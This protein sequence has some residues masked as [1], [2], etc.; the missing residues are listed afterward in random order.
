MARGFRKS[1]DFNNFDGCGF[2]WKWFYRRLERDLTEADVELIA[3]GDINGDGQTDYSLSLSKNIEYTFKGFF[4]HSFSWSREIEK[5]LVV[6]SGDDGPKVRDLERT[7]GVKGPVI[8]TRALGD[9]NGDGF[10]DFATFVGGGAYYGIGGPD[11]GPVGYY[12]KLVDDVYI[13]FGGSRQPATSVGNL[14][15]IDGKVLN[16]KSLGDIN[17]DGID[18]MAA[19]VGSYYGRGAEAGYYGKAIDD[20]YV[21]LGGKSGLAPISLGA[22]GFT[23]S[24][25]D[26]NALG[27]INGDGFVDLAA[28]VG[29]YYGYY[30]RDPDE[31]SY[32]GQVTED[33]FVLFGSEDGYQEKQSLTGLVDIKAKVVGVDAIG[34]IN[35][36]GLSDFA[37]ELGGYY[38]YY[39][40]GIRDVF[41]FLGGDET[42]VSLGSLAGREKTAI[43]VFDLGDINGDGL[44][45]IGIGTA[46]YYG[47][48]YGQEVEDVLV[49]FGNPDGT[50]EVANLNDFVGSKEPLH[51][52]TALGDI[53]G[54]GFEDFTVACGGYYGPGMPGEAILVFGGPDVALQS[55]NLKDFG[56]TDDAFGDIKALGDTNGDGFADFSIAGYYGYYG[57]DALKGSS[58]VVYGGESALGIA[59]FA[60]NARLGSL[61]VSHRVVLDTSPLGETFNFTDDLF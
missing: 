33:V 8:E 53:N 57:S 58:Y 31:I 34:D 11:A 4:G 19:S 24:V 35:G 21:I 37:A 28:T 50:R 51:G 15:G 12:G 13:T 52:A 17:G 27:D 20:T 7:T 48:Y 43:D 49:L 32:Y 44:T 61:E 9:I 54:D 46:G 55:L 22:L 16:L 29:S 10:D 47:G 38:G 25:L 60:K 3:L 39:G 59:D 6:L 5:N 30:G 40:S 1:F 42:P 26:V 18:D 56:L 41:L 45:D 36:D 14:D 23:S 2:F